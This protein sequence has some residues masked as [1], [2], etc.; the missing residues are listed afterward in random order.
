MRLPSRRKLLLLLALGAPAAFGASYLAFFTPQ[1]A[2][3]VA[4][5]TNRAAGVTPGTVGIADPTGRWSVQNGSEAGYR[6][7]EK[8]ARL[9]A[10]TDAVGK[11]TA[12][13]GTVTIEGTGGK[14]SLR[15]VSL[16]ADLT[17]L[18]SDSARRDNALRT[19]GLQTEA[20]PTATFTSSG[21]VPLPGD[22][23]SGSPVTF[24]LPGSL[25][26]H[27]VT[28]QVSI[29]IRAQ[30]TSGRVEVAGSST[31]LMSQFDIIPPSVANIV[32]VRPAAT[33][34]FRLLLAKTG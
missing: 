11:T 20:F 7:R 1:T 31:F 24:T 16:V 5:S 6:V 19:R 4:L 28:R 21:P 8:L 10:P 29:P 18:R 3:P 2:D 34:E 14:Y 32:T 22:A 30:L 27:G 15:D 12:V 25:S 33:M 23:G 17:R 26:I 9:P 13:N